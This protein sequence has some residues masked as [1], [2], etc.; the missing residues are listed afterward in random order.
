MSEGYFRTQCRECDLLVYEG[1]WIPPRERH[2]LHEHHRAL[3]TSA[4]P[5]AP[6]TTTPTSVTTVPAPLFLL[7]GE[8]RESSPRTSGSPAKNTLLQQVR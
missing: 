4:P 2:L 8:H 1:P 7:R 3:C 5:T 6:T